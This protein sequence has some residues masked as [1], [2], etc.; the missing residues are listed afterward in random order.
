MAMVALPGQWA[1]PDPLRV[2]STFQSQLIDAS[3][4]KAAGIFGVP[5]TGNIDRLLFLVR[6]VTTPQTLQI[7]LQTVDGTTGDPSG[8]PYG[9]M[10]A[11]IQAAPASNTQ[12]E[13]T[14]GTP[15]AAVRGDL[16]AA[17]IEY[18]GSVGSLNV[19]AV[20]ANQPTNSLG[21]P[22]GDLFTSAW[23]KN[24]NVFPAIGVR[25]DDGSYYDAN[26]C[27]WSAITSYTH[28]SGTGTFDEYALNFTLPWGA[29]LVG[30]WQYLGTT[31]G[32]NFEMTLYTGTTALLTQAVDGDLRSA[33]PAYCAY[34]FAG[35]YDLVAGTPYRLSFRPTTAN[36]IVTRTMVVNSAAYLNAMPF[37]T[38]FSMSK[39]LDLGAWTDVATE[40]PMIGLIID[41]LDVAPTI[42]IPSVLAQ[43]NNPPRAVRY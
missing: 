30:A 3:G 16:V 36:S 20:Q 13:V 2:S 1:F 24:A 26:T 34:P 27:P 7:G 43:V 41:A 22:Y 42:S 38:A 19:G 39:R 25:Y 8:S 29:R 28:N 31:A 35:T 4:E 17:V 12:Y 23:A 21:F 37:G 40:R 18:P 33:T 15:A 5:K 32:S 6:T 9:G 14:L 10:V 11:G